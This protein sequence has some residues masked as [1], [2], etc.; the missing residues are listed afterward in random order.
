M[1]MLMCWHLHRA[2]DLVLEGTC[3]AASLGQTMI[4]QGL[5]HRAVDMF[6]R[7]RR[8]IG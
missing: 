8:A 5:L 6:V 7:V 3:I 4:Y 2:D 1:L